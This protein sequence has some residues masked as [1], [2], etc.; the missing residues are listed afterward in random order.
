MFSVKPVLERDIGESLMRSTILT[1]LLLLIIGP[2]AFAQTKPDSLKLVDTHH[3]ESFTEGETDTVSFTFNKAIDTTATFPKTG[4]L[5]FW[6]IIPVDSAEI[7]SIWVSE[8]LKT[9]SYQV[10]HKSRSDYT[11]LLESARSRDST[12]LQRPYKLFY[13]LRADDLNRFKVSGQ[14]IF[15]AFGKQKSG[16]ETYN[17]QERQYTYH[18]AALPTKKPTGEKSSAYTTDSIKYISSGSNPY[19]INEVIPG[20][21]WPVLLRRVAYHE[22]NWDKKT[23]YLTAYDPDKTSEVTIPDSIVIKENDMNDIELKFFD[24]TSIEDRDQRIESFEIEAYPNPFN[25]TT[26]IEV[27]VART[28][29]YSVSVYDITGRRIKTIASKTQLSRGIHR[30]HL[31]MAGQATGIYMVVVE[32]STG[33]YAKQIS[34]IK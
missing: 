30:F 20:T 6:R 18:I 14:I 29:R 17:L 15:V 13:K 1:Y 2:T 3:P 10:E 12:Y 32:S 31:D 4:P 27:T 7:D 21:Y 22:D 9:V 11:W 33:R 8:D 24:L 16:S 23:T 26:N 34:Y 19:E 5:G 25:H 28:D